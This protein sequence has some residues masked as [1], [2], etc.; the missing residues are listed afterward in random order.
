MY[1][2]QQ[3]LDSI[4]AFFENEFRLSN[5]D[6][7]EIAGTSYEIANCEYSELDTVVKSRLQQSQLTC[8]ILEEFSQD[9]AEDMFLRLQHGTPLNAAEKRRAINGNMRD[10]VRRLQ[11][12]WLTDVRD[13]HRRV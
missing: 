8:V 13:C 5:E 6:P 1:D 4:Y 12:L 7:I 10:V 11:S 3:R 2:G 9:Q